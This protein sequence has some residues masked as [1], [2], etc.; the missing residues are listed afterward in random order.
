MRK[1]EQSLAEVL[2]LLKKKYGWQEKMMEVAVRNAWYRLLGPVAVHHTVSIR[3]H[4]QTL[5]VQLNSSVL[6]EELWMHKE[7]LLNAL[8]EEIGSTTSEIKKITLL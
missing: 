2:D 7:K 1:N 8:N 5:T 6:R 3:Y 4:K